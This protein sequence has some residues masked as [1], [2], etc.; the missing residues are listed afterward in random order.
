MRA[1]KEEAYTAKCS[2]LNQLYV[3][4]M[5][6]YYYVH[7]E[8]YKRAFGDRGL[9]FGELDTP[10]DTQF[11]ECYKTFERDLPKEKI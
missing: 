7:P 10:K 1:R 4:K 2:H 8:C 11:N 9:E 6:T 5:C 3:A